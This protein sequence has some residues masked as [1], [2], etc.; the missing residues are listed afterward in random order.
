M[1]FLGSCRS[2]G[3]HGRD[4]PTKTDLL[5]RTLDEKGVEVTQKVLG[6]SVLSGGLLRI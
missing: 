2:F 5:P 4:P 6:E 1:K 3:I